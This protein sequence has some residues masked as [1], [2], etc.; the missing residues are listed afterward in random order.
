MLQ[1]I[2]NLLSLLQNAQQIGDRIQSARDELRTK[3]VMGSAGGG[4][5]EVEVNGL[6]EVLRVKL[7]PELIRRQDSEMVE[8]LLPAA[9]N[10]ALRKARELH[11]EMAKSAT[12]D[13]SIPGLEEALSRLTQD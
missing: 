6:C 5:V 3:R 10:Q 8:D 4:L 7:D 13:F 2:S 12:K 1:G 9:I 11:V